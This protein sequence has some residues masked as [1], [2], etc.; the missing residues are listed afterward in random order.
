MSEAA[1][2]PDGGGDIAARFDAVCQRMAERAGALAPDG[3][4]EDDLDR[5]AVELTRTVPKR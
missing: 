5:I 3:A 1:F 2:V 4:T